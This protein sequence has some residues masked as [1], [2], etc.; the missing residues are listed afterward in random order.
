MTYGRGLLASHISNV[1]G[2]VSSHSAELVR[3]LLLSLG[4]EG[5]LIRPIVP[6]ARLR[7]AR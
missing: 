4:K 2:A 3:G 5:P 1:D 6:E 7:S